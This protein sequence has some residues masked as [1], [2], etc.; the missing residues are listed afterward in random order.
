M[1]GKLNCFL[2][3]QCYDRLCAAVSDALNRPV[4]AVIHHYQIRL[5]VDED[6]VYYVFQAGVKGETEDT[7]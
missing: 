7:E 6:S 2:Y 1:I 5:E 3:Q 4:S